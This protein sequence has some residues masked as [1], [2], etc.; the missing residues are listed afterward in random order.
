MSGL[1][2]VGAVAAAIVALSA[3]SL[4]KIEE[5]KLKRA[6]SGNKMAVIM[7]FH[8]YRACGRVLSSEFI[9]GSVSYK[10]TYTHTHMHPT[11]HTC[12]HAIVRAQGNVWGTG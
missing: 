12:T 7:S 10:H 8:L 1:A 11:K 4:H 5:G 2:V 3:F 9:A 6:A